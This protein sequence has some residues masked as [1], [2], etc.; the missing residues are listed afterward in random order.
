MRWGLIPHRAFMR[1]HANL[2]AHT[3]EEP[4]SAFHTDLQTLLPDLTRFAR[5]LTRNEDD[6][7]DLV[8]DC[9]ERALRKQC[10]FQDGTSL[11]S[12][13]FTLMRNLFIS[14]KRRIALDK[15]YVATLDDDGF[16]VQ[17]PSQ[18]TTV[19]LKETMRA[20]DGLSPVE[21]HAIVALGVHEASQHDVADA[22]QEPVGTVK[23]RLCR[24]R[25][26]LR[27]MLGMDS[28]AMATA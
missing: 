15:R 11:K 5:V 18:L 1:V 7:Y 19:F 26:H 13:L 27:A 14:Q 2:F 25:A 17:R 3:E 22:L 23:S 28:A 9:V 16:R 24:G 8:Q 12:W 21:R 6:A 10:L 20:M 4:M